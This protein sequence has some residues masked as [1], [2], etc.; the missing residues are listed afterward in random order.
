M[1]SVYHRNR[2]TFMASNGA[3][4][5][6]PKGFT[7]MGDVATDNPN[8]AYQLSNNID[9]AWRPEAPCR[10]TSVGDVLVMDAGKGARLEVDSLGFNSF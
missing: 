1:I 8:E 4:E 7:F 6:F 3:R 5:E 10:S 9:G 2:P